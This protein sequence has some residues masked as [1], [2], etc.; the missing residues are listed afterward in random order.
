MNGKPIKRKKKG[1]PVPAGHGRVRLELSGHPGQ[2]VFV[3]GTFNNWEPM[4]APLAS[5]GEGRWAIE[6]A[7]PPGQY[8][9]RFIVDEQWIDDPRAT[10]FVPNIYGGINCIFTVTA[11][12]QR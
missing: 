10:E 12:G 4:A 7:L 1:S 6:L 5:E 3:A 2:K 8:E 11:E 9:Y